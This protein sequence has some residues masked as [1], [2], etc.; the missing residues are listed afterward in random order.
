MMQSGRYQEGSETT[1]GGRLP[2]DG[3]TGTNPQVLING[4]TFRVGTEPNLTGFPTTRPLGQERC[5]KTLAME[6]K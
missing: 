4:L 6:L 5:S 3:P 1:T 2:I